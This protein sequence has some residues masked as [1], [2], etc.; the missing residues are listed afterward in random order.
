M[1]PDDIIIPDLLTE[2]SDGQLRQRAREMC[3]LLHDLDPYLV[4]LAETYQ[5]S[6]SESDLNAF[7]ALDAKRREI[8]DVFAQQ[9][10]L[11]RNR[12]MPIGCE[13]DE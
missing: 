6:L 5:Q 3:Q 11:M 7:L 10:V 1:D 13:Y 8:D 12:N 2:G 4:A 9:L